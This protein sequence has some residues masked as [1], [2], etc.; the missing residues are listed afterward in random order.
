METT[1]PT[2]PG[3]SLWPALAAVGCVLTL[4]ACGSSA[5]PSSDAA[6]ATASRYDSFLKFSTC[7]RSHGVN[8]PDPTFNSGG[9]FGFRQAFRALD[10][11]SPNFQS[12]LTACRTD[13]PRFGRFGR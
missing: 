7:M 10:R 3:H 13:R 2:C 12:A 4:A 6:T 11:N 9:S 1:P 8:V 5:K